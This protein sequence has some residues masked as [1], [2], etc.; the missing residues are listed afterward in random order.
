MELVNSTRMVAGYTMGL[1][2]SGRELLV[3]VVKGTFDMPLDGGNVRLADEQ[4]PLVMAD[5]FSGEPG[6]SA[7]VDE[8][9]FA[10]TKRR[11]D[12]L[13]KGSAYA[14]DGRPTT[15]V[16]VGLRV[17]RMVKRFDV[18]GNRYWRIG[19]RG[20]TASA[21]E[22]FAVMPISYDCAFGGV[23]T[24]HQDPSKH[25]AFARNPVGKGFHTQWR[26]EWVDNSPL[27]NTQ[28]LGSPITSPNTQTAVPM[29][30]GL[31]GR[32]WEPRVHYAGTYDEKWLEEQSPFLP[33]DF[34]EQY[35]QAAP[36]DQQIPHPVGGEQIALLNLTSEGRRSFSVPVFDAPIHFFPR[37]GRREE[38]KLTLD[39]IQLEPDIQR[40]SLI[41]RSTRP[42][43]RNVFEIAQILV[44]KKSREWWARRESVS[45]PIKLEIVPYG[46]D[47]SGAAGG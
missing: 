32:W 2:P 29:S 19:A 10:P 20:V 42:V 23:D 33:V 12:V 4:L 41:W 9:D 7:P 16:E 38:G 28:E 30:F 26:P 14:P 8:A 40:L 3:V 13:L 25:S 39:T 43:R 46:T 17:D 34:D 45:F 22:P 36:L 21:P 24:R 27:P 5:T 44:G 11:C 35:Y 31:L 37:R 6:F 15:Q 1:E 47:Q 18:V